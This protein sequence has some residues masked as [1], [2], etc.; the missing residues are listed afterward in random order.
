[1]FTQ[2]D[3]PAQ[4]VVICIFMAQLFRERAGIM[5]EGR[6]YLVKSGQVLNTI[7]PKQYLPKLCLEHSR[8]VV[9]VWYRPGNVGFAHIHSTTCQGWRGGQEGVL[10]IT[11]LL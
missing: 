6:S 7:F 3:Y 8:R 11:V 4:Y 5:A 9:S 2:K 10:Y 1:M